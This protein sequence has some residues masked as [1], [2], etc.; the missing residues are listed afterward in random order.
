M[1]NILYDQPLFDKVWQKRLISQLMEPLQIKSEHPFIT[2]DGLDLSLIE[3]N[4]NLS[5][6]KRYLNHERALEIVRQLQ[7]ASQEIY[8]S[9]NKP[10]SNPA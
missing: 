2:T 3:Y 1:Q 8:G 7:L 9:K 10:A 6:E 5:Y 4:L